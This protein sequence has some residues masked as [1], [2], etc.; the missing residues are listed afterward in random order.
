M[1]ILLDQAQDCIKL[2][3]DDEEFDKPPIIPVTSSYPVT[4]RPYVPRMSDPQRRSK[5]VRRSTNFPQRPSY[6]FN[7]NIPVTSR[8]VPDASKFPVNYTDVPIVT[9]NFIYALR[10]IYIP[11]QT[12][13]PFTTTNAPYR[14]T[15]LP[16]GITYFPR[17]ANV[18]VGVVSNT[19]GFTRHFHN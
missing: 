7:T 10:D 4:R 11:F 8:P 9:P 17:K 6:Q 19:V 5:N 1:E 2:L 14:T 13:V 12:F 3:A 15:N 16:V 18:L